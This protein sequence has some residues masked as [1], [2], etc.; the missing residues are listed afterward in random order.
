MKKEKVKTKVNKIKSKNTETKVKNNYFFGILSGILG[1]IIASIPWILVYV[2]GNFML[3]ALSILIP[4][5]IFYG[6]K[7]FG[8]KTT[9]ALPTI[10]V[11]LS[12]LITVLTMLVFMPIFLI[13]SQGEQIDFNNIKYLY[14]DMKFLESISLDAIIAII[15]AIFGAFIIGVNIKKK[16]ENNELSN[17]KEIEKNKNK[18]I[19]KIITIIIGLIFVSTMVG[20]IIFNQVKINSPKEVTD[21]VISFIIDAGW[22]QSDSEYENE[23]LYFKYINNIQPIGEIEEGDYSKNPAYVDVMYLKNDI[24]TIPDMEAV[25]KMAKESILS[26]EIEP[27]TYEEDV[28]TLSS[29]YN[30]LKLKIKYKS[31][32]ELIEYAYYILKGDMIAVID[33]YSYNVQDE[34][35]I[36]ETIEKITESFKWVE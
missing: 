15:F 17:S 36:K 12:I 16:T 33:T 31:D 21:G 8:G 24:E 1:G 27:E 18:I 19:S 10:L 6:Y 34:L 29:G 11:I 26:R 20:V 25:K 3:S 23:W 9:K 4:V 5:G 14:E 30:I 32:Y 2:Y 28:Q 35:E 13:Q 22:K 7:L